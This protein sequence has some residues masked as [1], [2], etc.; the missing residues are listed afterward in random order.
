MTPDFEDALFQFVAGQ[1]TVTQYIGAAPRTRFFKLKQPQATKTPAMTQQRAGR[2][3]Q[4]LPCGP[5][6][7]VLIQLQVDTYAKTWA[8]MAGCAKAF[9]RALEGLAYPVY[10]GSGDS[11]GNQI[12]V[13]LAALVNEF[14]S[15]DPEP[16]ICRRTQ[17]WE[18]WVFEP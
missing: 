12:R 10:L 1:P 8:E 13:K 15:D 2:T 14:D 18:F 16:G 5:D 7:A 17:F 4:Q 9:R 11:P 3:T 6:G